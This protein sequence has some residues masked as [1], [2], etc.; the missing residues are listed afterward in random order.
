MKSGGAHFYKL[1]FQNVCKTPKFIQVELRIRTRSDPLENRIRI[2]ALIKKVN[3]DS[4]QLRTLSAFPTSL[5]IEDY[6]GE[7]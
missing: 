7:E 3:P 2:F 6:K 1:N 5:L 4:T